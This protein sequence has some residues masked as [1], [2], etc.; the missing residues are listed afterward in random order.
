M[1]RRMPREHIPRIQ[2]EILQIIAA[3]V[4]ALVVSVANSD[5]WQSF[6]GA[7]QQP[8]TV[9]QAEQHYQVLKVVD[10]DTLTIDYNSKRQTLRLIGINTPETVDP[11]RP[12]ECF[13][14][15]ASDKA[16]ELMEGKH[17]RIE[18]DSTQGTY[19]TFQRLLTY[20]YTEGGTFVNKYMI[21]QGYAY[22]YTYDEPYKYQTEFKEAE[23]QAKSSNRG[24][25]APGV[26]EY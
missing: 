8:A 2:K 5:I 17:V 12:V 15:E 14:K 16:K 19:D 18:L 9:R 13:G 6:T 11:R 23:R 24:L 25:W 7:M 4:V 3:L 1:L 22:E 21:E 20:V 10:G 26:C